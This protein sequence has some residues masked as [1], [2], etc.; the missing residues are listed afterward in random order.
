[1]FVEHGSTEYIFYCSLVIIVML[2]IYYINFQQD[3][4]QV[5]RA[6]TWIV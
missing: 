5:F 2:T 4:M 6:C 3:D 1:M